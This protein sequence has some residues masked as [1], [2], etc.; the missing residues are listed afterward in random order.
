MIEIAVNKDLHFI[1][2]FAFYS[3]YCPIFFICGGISQWLWQKINCICCTFHVSVLFLWSFR[4]A[5]D[6]L[7]QL[8]WF[9]FEGYIISA[10]KILTWLSICWTILFNFSSWLYMPWP[11]QSSHNDLAKNYHFIVTFFV[12]VLQLCTFNIAID[13]MT[14][15]SSLYLQLII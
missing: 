13:Y 10:F 3:Q 7:C 2:K 1:Y 12:S 4:M 8:W 15:T 11:L 14:C 5:T 9:M 6:S